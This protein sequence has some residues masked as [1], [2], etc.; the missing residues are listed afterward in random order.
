MKITIKTIDV[1]L[2]PSLNKFIEEKLKPLEKFLK[3]FEEEGDVQIS[4]EL[5]RTTQH[6]KHGEV[7]KASLGVRLGKKVLHAEQDADDARVAIDRARDVLRSEIEKH[8]SQ[9]EPKRGIGSS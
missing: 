5:A 3:R 7:F 9:L 4:C 1:D 6:H 8:K 2:T